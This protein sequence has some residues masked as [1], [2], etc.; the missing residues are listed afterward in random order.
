LHHWKHNEV[1]HETDILLSALSEPIAEVSADARMTVTDLGRGF[2]QIAGH[3]RYRETPNVPEIMRM[4]AKPGIRYPAGSYELFS[5]TRHPCH[6]GRQ[7][8]VPMAQAFFSFVSRHVRSA[9]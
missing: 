9:A 2:F 6:P 8:D 3:Y 4:A 5:R 7:Q 1:L